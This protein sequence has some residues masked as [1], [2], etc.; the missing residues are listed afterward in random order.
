MARLLNVLLVLVVVGYLATALAGVVVAVLVDKLL[1]FASICS[2]ETMAPLGSSVLGGKQ[3]LFSSRPDG[4][5]FSSERIVRSVK[6]AAA[7]TADGVV[8]VFVRLLLLPMHIPLAPL[9][10]SA[11]DIN[12]LRPT[13]TPL[14][15]L[16]RNGLA[17]FAC[18]S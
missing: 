16:Q 11:G 13:P 8:E 18:C 12:V 14:P 2:I 6:A 3:L 17:P 4:L 9:F 1:L 10:D 7:A 15:L 5:G